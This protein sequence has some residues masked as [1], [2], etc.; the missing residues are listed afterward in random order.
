MLRSAVADLIGSLFPVRCVG[1]GRSRDPVCEYCAAT[2][3]LPPAMPPPPPVRA[4]VA[5]CAYEGVARELITRA[6]YRNHR[7]LLAWGADVVAATVLDTRLSFDTITWAPAS[8]ARFA[9]HGVD[10]GEVLARAVAR[11]LGVPA[12][13]LLCRPRGRAQT[14]LDARARRRGPD[15][16]ATRVLDGV[17]VLVVDDVATTGGTLAA[18]ARALVARGAS[19]VVAATIARTP[20]HDSDPS[21]D[22]AGRGPAY[23]PAELFG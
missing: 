19:G 21:H 18:A 10:H 22:S 4:W 2:L 8:A 6:K 15:L 13:G 9:R 5:C 14:G 12:R 16:Y 3:V 20:A 1:C 11:K 23:T 17:D 7:A